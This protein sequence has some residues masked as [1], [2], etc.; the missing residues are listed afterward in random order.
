MSHYNHVTDKHEVTISQGKR[1]ILFACDNKFCFCPG[2]G[3]AVEHVSLPSDKRTAAA[4]GMQHDD[5][6][7]TRPT[8]VRRYEMRLG[9]DFYLVRKP[10]LDRESIR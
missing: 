2:V 3:F 8:T 6:D 10:V 5:L 9:F 7:D 4:L 1:D